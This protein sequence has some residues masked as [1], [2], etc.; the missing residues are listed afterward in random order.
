MYNVLLSHAGCV[1]TLHGVTANIHEAF[2]VHIEDR[3]DTAVTQDHL[4]VLA[5][6]DPVHPCPVHGEV[7]QHRILL[8]RLPTN[9]E[10]VN[11]WTDLCRSEGQEQGY[12]GGVSGGHLRTF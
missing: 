2:A 3:D 5:N 11:T 12:D 9:N 8:F 6:L 1:E 10:V 7:C 4:P